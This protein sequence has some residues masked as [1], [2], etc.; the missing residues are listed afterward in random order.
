MDFMNFI[1]GINPVILIGLA[2]LIAF[3]ILKNILKKVVKIILL[4]LGIAAITGGSIST[5]NL[6]NYASSVVPNVQDVI[7]S[8]AQQNGI[9]LSTLNENDL[10]SLN[11][12][13]KTNYPKVEV[14]ND[15]GN[16]VLEVSKDDFFNFKTSVTLKKSS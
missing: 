14:K 7:N 15:N 9:D 13:I 5:L 11:E 16:L 4:I 1:Q 3:I 10:N 8:Y 12:Y 2:I 6:K